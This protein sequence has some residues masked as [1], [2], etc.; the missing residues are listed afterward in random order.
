MESLI[1]YFLPTILALGIITSYEDIKEGKIRNKYVATA[2]A[3][4]IAI[5]LILLVSGTEPTKLALLSATDFSLAL[6]LGFL[7]YYAGWWSAGDAKLY[8]AYVLLIPATVY[9]NIN[10]FRISAIIMNT[11]APLFVI[12]TAQLIM[13]TTKKQ[14]QSALQNT[15]GKD[16]LLA[17]IAIL[18]LSWIT[19]L[20]FLYAGI[21]TNYV[22]NLVAIIFLIKIA[23]T[24]F[25]KNTT[26]FICGLLAIRLVADFNT[27]TSSRFWT[28]TAILCTLYLAITA[29]GNLA[30][31]KKQNVKIRDISAGMV[32][33]EFITK[34]GVKTEKYDGKKEKYLL[35]HT[36]RGLSE[37]DVSLLKRMHQGG[38]LHFNTLKTKQAMTFATYIFIGAIITIAIKGDL[39]SVIRQHI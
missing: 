22:I 5:H 24:V 34:E 13:Q 36:K 12:L 15:L 32:L 2:I 20:V 8:A 38:N 29:L 3:L 1:I 31:Q 35:H 21:P 39:I 37:E 33:T 11:L 9:V 19:R 25:K 18:S 27:I 7:I 23:K 30:E 28:S 14:K 17:I 10:G 4:G 16:L 26:Y 6:I